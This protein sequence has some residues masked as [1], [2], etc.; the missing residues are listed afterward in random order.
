MKNLIRL[1]T[2]ANKLDKRGLNKEAD[3]LDKII[4]KVSQHDKEWEALSKDDGSLGDPEL[5][6]LLSEYESENPIEEPS[7]DELRAMEQGVDVFKGEEDNAYANLLKKLETEMELFSDGAGKS[8]LNAEDY[9][10][11]E[12]IKQELQDVRDIIKQREMDSGTFMPEA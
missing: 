11:F 7:D 5:D 8:M 6:R 3:T 4:K 10:N 2:I 1:I 9:D 12:L